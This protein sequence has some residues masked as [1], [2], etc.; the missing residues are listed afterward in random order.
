MRPLIIFALLLVISGRSYA[1]S[2]S[3]GI[4]LT[5]KDFAQRRLSYASSCDDQQHAV[6]LGSLFNQ[7]IVTVNYK[8]EKLKLNK[9]ELFGYR[10]CTKRVF[11][12]YKDLEFRIISTVG[13]YIY[14][15]EE[16]SG[17]GKNSEIADLFFFSVTI[18][19]DLV[20]LT[21]D[22]LRVAYARNEKFLDMVD[23]N[24]NDD[25]ELSIYDKT[26]KRY[27]LIRLYEESLR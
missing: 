7:T 27:R 13:I 1:Q 15:R 3:T 22:N 10:D 5:S 26:H 9:S 25:I 2:D 20:P 11:R 12:F 23:S 24:F 18:D 21:K 4:Y 6:K 17:T 14:F 16:E 8:N 19:S